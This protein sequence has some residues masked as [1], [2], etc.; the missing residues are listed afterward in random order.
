ME[1]NQKNSVLVYHDWLSAF[2]TLSAE[3]SKQLIIAI[4]KYSMSDTEPDQ[5]SASFNMAW[6]FIKTTLQR[7]KEKYAEKCARNAENGKKGGRRSTKNQTVSEKSERLPKKAKKAD[8]DSD[9]DNDNDSDNDSDNDT[10]SCN[11]TLC[12]FNTEQKMYGTHQN[13]PLSESKYEQYKAQY[14]NIDEIIENY[15]AMV[16]N[17][18]NTYK[19]NNFNCFLMSQK[20]NSATEAAP[21]K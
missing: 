17:N 5:Q 2:E 10:Y 11:R 7:N 15:S 21:P 6:S 12:N 19:A 4:I 13:I 1:L 9:N 3:E 18:P 8:N 16:F 20:K 14:S